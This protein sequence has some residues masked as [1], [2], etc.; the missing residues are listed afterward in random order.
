MTASKLKPALRSL[1]REHGL[2][3]VLKSLGEIAE[4]RHGSV[5]QL[6][7]RSNGAE[8]KVR[9]RKPRLTAPEYVEK[10]DIP[11][12]K[13]V[14]VAELAKRFE[15]KDFLPNF[16]AIADFCRTYEIKVPASKVRANTI[17]HVFK[18]IAYMEIAE[19]E[20]IRDD[21]MF[22]GPSRLGP[23]A[24]AIRNFSRTPAL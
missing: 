14:V 21:G 15:Q 22:S 2:G 3:E 18:L 10:M 16:A 1:V 5:K 24:D 12:D 6:A 19:V 13:S 9:R 17:P 8:K 11:A 4:S 23:I 20:R 7:V